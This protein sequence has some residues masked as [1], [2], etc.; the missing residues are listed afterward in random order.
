MAPVTSIVMI[1]AERY[2]I[3]E[4]VEVTKNEVKGTGETLNHAT[5]N[6]FTNS[7]SESVIW[8]V[9]SKRSNKLHR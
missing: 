6:A 7:Y 5:V 8:A 2:N 4:G 3:Y 1:G 9:L